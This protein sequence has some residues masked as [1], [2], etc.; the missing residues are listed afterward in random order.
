MS[1]IKKPS[2]IAPKQA[3]AMLIYGSPGSGKSSLGCSAPDAVLFDYDGGVN[4]INAAHRIPTVQIS[5]WED[6]EA[7]IAEINKELP[8]TKSIIIDTAGKM[9][10]YM[11]QS[12]IK[13]DPKLGQRDGSLALKGYGVRKNMFINFV[14]QLTISGRNVIFIA[15][16][17]EE[18]RGDETVMRPEI[19]G[20]SANDLI[21]ELDLVGYVRMI[22]NDRTISFS[23]CESYYAKNTCNLPA[24]IKIPL[25]VDEKGQPIG[26]NDYLCTI[27]N[28]YQ[29]S[30]L[31]AVELNKSFDKLVAENNEVIDAAEDVESL[32]EAYKTVLA[33]Q[34]IFNSK[35]LAAQRLADKAASLGCKFDKKA[36]AYVATEA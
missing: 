19:G 23:P 14:K 1:L 7:A 34:V 24:V 21:K 5:S 28:A 30:Q 11:T 10:D 6:T 12:I 25:T 16:D 20:S 27:I 33:N 8:D 2:E 3:V 35:L 22:G 26:N 29:S 32:N 18:K 17:R 4:R 15:H 36:K 13:R 9:L 31:K